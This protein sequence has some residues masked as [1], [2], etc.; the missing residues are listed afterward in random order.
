LPNR[1]SRRLGH[2]RTEKKGINE[3][4]KVKPTKAVAQEEAHI[5]AYLNCLNEKSRKRLHKVKQ[6]T[7]VIE[8]TKPFERRSIN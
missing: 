4:L 2:E 1:Q 3:N 8:D 6:K 7:K 5:V